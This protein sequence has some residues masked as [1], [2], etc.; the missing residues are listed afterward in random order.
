MCFTACGCVGVNH[1][2]MLGNSLWTE[3]NTAV[4]LDSFSTKEFP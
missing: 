3:K 4:F 2:G 1:C